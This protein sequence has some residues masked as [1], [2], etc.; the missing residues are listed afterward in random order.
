[1]CESYK[2]PRGETP[3]V[4][5]VLSGVTGL[6][7][8]PLWTGP[9]EAPSCASQL[10]QFP[11]TW[12][13]GEYLLSERMARPEETHAKFCLQFPGVCAHPWSRRLNWSLLLAQERRQGARQGVR[14]GRGGGQGPREG[15]AAGGG[16]ARGGGPGP[17]K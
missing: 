15:P 13:A 4:M 2:G 17:P 6:V 8:G 9:L 7:C 10:G 16:E 11:G 3:V 14:A 12:Q 1:M 5:E